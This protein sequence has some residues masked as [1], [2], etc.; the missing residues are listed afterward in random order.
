MSESMS[1]TPDEIRAVR[2]R[3]GLTQ[4]ALAQRVAV[5]RDTVAS[6]EIGRSRPLGPAEILIRQIQAQLDATEAP[7]A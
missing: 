3:A 7:T 6:W 1:I 2:K 5:T 4:A